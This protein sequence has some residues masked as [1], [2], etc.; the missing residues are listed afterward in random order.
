MYRFFIK[1]DLSQVR[2]VIHQARHHRGRGSE[3]R[4][5]I[6]QFRERYRLSSSWKASARRKL[7][8]LGRKPC[9]ND[10]EAGL[11]GQAFSALSRR[12]PESRKASRSRSARRA[13]SCIGHAQIM[14]RADSSSAITAMR[15]RQRKHGTTAITTPATPRGR[16][17]TA[18]SGMSDAST[19]SSSPPAT[20]SGRS[21]SSRV[22]MELPYVLECAVTARSGSDPRTGC[23]GDDCPRQGQ[24]E[25][26][27]AEEGNPE[28]RQDATPRLTSTRE[29]SSSWTSSRRR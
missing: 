27:R 29:S 14:F 26:G 23:Q 24:G 5:V 20:A 25:V 12:D 22:I 4:G 16:M 10:A 8:L 1:E 21:R 11:Y 18:T 2:S 3:P 7:P 28:L 15:R 13:R 17:R 9:R 19:T 6:Q